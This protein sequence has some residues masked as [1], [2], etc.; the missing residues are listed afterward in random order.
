[1]RKSVYTAGRDV[2]DLKSFRGMLPGPFTWGGLVISCIRFIK[3]KVHAG[4]QCG[5][6]SAWHY[7]RRLSIRHRDSESRQWQPDSQGAELERVSQDYRDEKREDSDFVG[8]LLHY[9]I[10]K[11]D[12]KGYCS[13]G[14]PGLC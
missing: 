13:L 1:M 8:Q 3:D 14:D 7:P 11:R 9:L 12:N 2:V 6:R 10:S 4:V 5:S